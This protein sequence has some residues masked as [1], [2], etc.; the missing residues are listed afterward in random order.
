MKKNN[1]LVDK[2]FFDN[3]KEDSDHRDNII[4]ERASELIRQGKPDYV[5]IQRASYE[6]EIGRIK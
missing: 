5:A 6:F 3:L 4:N 2:N 1:K